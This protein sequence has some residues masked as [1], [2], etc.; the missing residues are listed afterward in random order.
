MDNMIFYKIIFLD[1]T[2]FTT[3]D[4][5]EEKKEKEKN[6]NEKK[7]FTKGQNRKT[8]KTKSSEVE[9]RETLIDTHMKLSETQNN[10]KNVR[11]LH[12]NLNAPKKQFLYK[13]QKNSSHQLHT[14]SRR[15]PLINMENDTSR[16]IA[17]KRTSRKKIKRL[18][19]LNLDKENVKVYNITD[20]SNEGICKGLNSIIF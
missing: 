16:R 6:H 3:N 2:F 4:F 13:W 8:S 11:L 7:K 18:N 5:Y 12:E 20:H 17:M 14:E 1:T 15:E 19:F 10:N 9:Q